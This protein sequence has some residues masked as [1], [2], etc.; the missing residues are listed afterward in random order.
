[1]ELGRQR[2]GRIYTFSTPS[3]YFFLFW[4]SKCCG[5]TGVTHHHTHG[6]PLVKSMGRQA[7]EVTVQLFIFS[8]A[9]GMV[10]GNLHIAHGGVRDTESNLL[11]F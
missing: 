3:F 4:K 8:V 2:E 6:F 1:M 5:F 9:S 10:Q 7:W 11:I